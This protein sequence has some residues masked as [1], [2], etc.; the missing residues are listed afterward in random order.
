M[1]SVRPS[2]WPYLSHAALS[3]WGGVQGV[4]PEQQARAENLIA[5]TLLRLPQWADYH[6]A[7]AKGCPVRGAA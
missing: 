3:F 2:R 5:I 7:E 6:T 4:T 1:D